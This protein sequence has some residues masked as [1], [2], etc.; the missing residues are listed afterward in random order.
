MIDSAS[1]VDDDQVIDDIQSDDEINYTFEY[2]SLQESDP[3]ENT[4]QTSV[5]EADRS[6]EADCLS[7][8]IISEQAG[9]TLRGKNGHIWST[10]K[11]KSSSKTSASNILHV[12]QGPA[13]MCKNI[14]DP[15]EI[16]NL[17]ITNEVISE[18]VKWTNV[19]MI[20]KRQKVVKITAT[21]RDTT[22]LE[23]R[24]FIGLL[25]LTAFMKDNHVST[26]DLFNP[27]FSGARYIAVMSKERFEFIVRCFRMDDKTL[28]PTLRP[29]DA[30]V[31]ARNVWEMFI[32][33][34]RNNYIPGS[35]VTIDEQ[36]IGFTGKCP[37][38]IYIPNKPDKDGIKFPMMCDANSKY[39][40][41]AAPY[42]GRR[43]NTG[44]IPLSDFYVQKLSKTIH[45]SNRN[46]TCNNWF[47]S[48]PLAKCL[49]EK[50]YNL[51][52]VGA[53]RSNNREIP[54]QLKNSRSRPLGSSM[55]CFD[56]PLTLV[57]YKSKPAKMVYL[58]SS[59]DENAIINEPSGKPEMILYYNQTKDGVDTFVEMCASMSCSR[60]TNRWPMAV[61]YGILD[62]AFANSAILYVHNMLKNNKKPLCRRELMKQLSTGLITPWMENRLRAPTLKRSLRENIKHILVKSTQSNCKNEK[63]ELEPKKRR[64]CNFCSYKKRRMSKLMCYKCKKAV[65]GEHKIVMC[66]DCS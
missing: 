41:D 2:V 6:F 27:T 32:K 61:F 58:L 50:P 53:L 31:P 12:S 19:E 1:E 3:S 47:T 65:C 35:E 24:A 63:E 42:I 25:T 16:F 20:S 60:K 66:I 14:I 11:A 56:G 62:M 34:C 38:R 22:D 30:F 33:Q 21:H 64:Y 51:T 18:I 10:T 5:I 44:G 46:I 9:N 54:E 39:M 57:S 45:G 49:L 55:F 15:V 23:I 8:P 29:N 26:D 4:D 48:I 13:P 28:R 52:L 40:I 59:C 36:L 43:T 7:R 17:F 37:F